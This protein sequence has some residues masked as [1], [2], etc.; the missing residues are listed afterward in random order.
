MVKDKKPSL[1]FLI[2]IKLNSSRLAYLKNKLG[3]E[4]CFVVDSMGRSEGLMLLWKN[5]MEIEIINY[6]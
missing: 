4:G 3:F 6:S 1:V 2:E 5:E